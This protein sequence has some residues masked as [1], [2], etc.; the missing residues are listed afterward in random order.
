M[1]DFLGMPSVYSDQAATTPQYTIIHNMYV[2]LI[3][4][5][6]I[7]GMHKLL[8][9]SYVPLMSKYYVWKNIV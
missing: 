6:S 8:L 1:T 3:A 9:C 5:Y 4:F 2:T 7:R